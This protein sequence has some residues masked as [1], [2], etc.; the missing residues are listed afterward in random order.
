LK[1]NK[2]ETK[3]T[4]R[5]NLLGVSFVLSVTDFTKPTIFATSG[6]Y[7]VTTDYTQASSPRTVATL[8]TTD[9][10]IKDVRRPERSV[11]TGQ[12]DEAIRKTLIFNTTNVRTSNLAVK[13]Y[14]ICVT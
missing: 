8:G 3:K 9:S 14:V 11:N 2:K 13:I 4:A 10:E 1:E 6:L 12:H 7:W 5:Y